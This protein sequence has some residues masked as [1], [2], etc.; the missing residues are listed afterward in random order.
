M[1]QF[2]S[3]LV[4]LAPLADAALAEGT[5]IALPAGEHLLAFTLPEGFVPVDE[6]EIVARLEGETPEAWTQ[7]LTLTVDPERIDQD[8]SMDVSMIGSVMQ[9]M[10]PDTLEQSWAASQDVPG[11]E[12]GGYGAWN[13]CGTVLGSDPPRSEQLFSFAISGPSGAYVLSRVV[14]GPAS[15]EG[16]DYDSDAI[17]AEIDLL[18]VGIK[19]CEKVPGEEAPYPSCIGG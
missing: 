13:S 2:F 1:K 6:G 19:V 9:E 15:E 17:D 18:I 16:L 14:R 12:R 11:T 3:A 10:C 5:L 7:A 8:P 4:L